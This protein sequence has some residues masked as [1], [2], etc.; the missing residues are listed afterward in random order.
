M[1]LKYFEGKNML[2]CLLLPWTSCWHNV[3]HGHQAERCGLFE[4]RR[5][6]S[7]AILPLFS[8]PTPHHWLKISVYFIINQYMSSFGVYFNYIAWVVSSFPCSPV[9]N[10]QT[11][12]YATRYVFSDIVFIPFN[13]S[14]RQYP[15][16]VCW[17]NI[18]LWQNITYLG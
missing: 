9:L 2:K 10:L 13:K 15:K 5:A 17:N 14:K 6:S 18:C 11:L 3:L 7:N 1:S 16:L 8:C 12:L 4:N